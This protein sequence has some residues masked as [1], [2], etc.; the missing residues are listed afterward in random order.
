MFFTE[1]WWTRCQK[2]SENTS[3]A[4]RALAENHLKHF[5]KLYFLF[6]QNI[7]TSRL[8]NN[9]NNKNIRG[10]KIFSTPA[11]RTGVQTLKE[12]EKVSLNNSGLKSTYCLPFNVSKMKRKHDEVRNM[13]QARLEH[14]SRH[15]HHGFYL[16]VFF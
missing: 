3:W 9:I 5:S 4:V 14:K 7:S 13:M 15:E 12:I 10:Q 6:A 1:R 11:R 2:L 16:D 8:P